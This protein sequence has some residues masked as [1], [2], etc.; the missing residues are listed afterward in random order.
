MTFSI[1]GIASVIGVVILAL[2][3]YG[4][5]EKLSAYLYMSAGVKKRLAHEYLSYHNRSRY[6]LYKWLAAVALNP[7]NFKKMKRFCFA[8]L[9]L[10][11]FSILSVLLTML[12]EQFLITEVYF[13]VSLI[14]TLLISKSG[15]SCA[16]QVKNDFD[17]GM[18]YN[19]ENSEYID[20][21]VN[22]KHSLF[23][24]FLNLIFYNLL[25]VFTPILIGFSL[26]VCGI[27]VSNS[28]AKQPESVMPEE[29]VTSECYDE[30]E[31][32]I[33]LSGNA[34]NAVINPTILFDKLSD[35]GL[36]CEDIS[37]IMISSNSQYTF[38]T[39]LRATGNGMSFTCYVL[40]D[41][42][43]A[44]VFCDS[45]VAPLEKGGIEFNTKNYRINNQDI[46]CCSNES[47]YGYIAVIYSDKSIFYIECENYKIE[48][49]NTFLEDNGLK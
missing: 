9:I 18:V 27:I 20:D 22:S 2:V 25:P 45:I 17:S 14:L 30:T 7:E 4:I 21:L 31:P 19:P 47:E 5:Y 13:F 48:W 46:T 39:C 35:E 8:P 34:G 29:S 16:K 44:D 6:K 3:D 26:F 40:D 43:D 33:I 28:Y 38:D 41:E 42:K 36:Y 12:T 15:F 11:V 37:D 24:E 10:V 23:W 32:S 49:L 1:L